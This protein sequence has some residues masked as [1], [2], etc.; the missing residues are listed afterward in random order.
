MNERQIKTTLKR[1]AN[2][3]LKLATKHNGSGICNTKF[4]FVGIEVTP[5]GFELWSKGEIV[6]GGD[7]KST[8]DFLVE[9]V[10]VVDIN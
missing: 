9:K 7:K 2:T 5:N 8:V 1:W 3:D 6:F 10:Y 4:G